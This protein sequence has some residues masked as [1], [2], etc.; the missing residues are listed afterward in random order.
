MQ[1]AWLG[2]WLYTPVEMGLNLIIKRRVAF[3]K[4]V[5]VMFEQIKISK[6]Q[7]LLHHFVSFSFFLAFLNT[8][9]FIII[10][11]FFLRYTVSV[12]DYI[13]IV[14]LCLYSL[15]ASPHNLPV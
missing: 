4:S 13:A 1:N 6:T 7:T 10:I 12:C 11:F 14:S 5:A 15:C 2:A 3:E 9:Y 8:Y